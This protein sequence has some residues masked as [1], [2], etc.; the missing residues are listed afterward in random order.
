MDRRKLIVGGG[1][2]AVAGT[3]TAVTGAMMPARAASTTD[4]AQRVLDQVNIDLGLVNPEGIQ[5][6]FDW[7]CADALAAP[8]RDPYADD[9]D[10]WVRRRMA[11][12]CRAETF[13]VA[14]TE[15]PQARS[16]LAFSYLA[17]S[18]DQDKPLPVLDPGMRVPAVLRILEPDFLPVLLGLITERSS[19]SREFAYALQ[20]T[21]D[22]LD[23]MVAEKL[24]EFPDDS[25]RVQA[26]PGNP[27]G[28]DAL[29]FT[30]GVVVF[31]AFLYWI[32]RG[33]K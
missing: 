24:R 32:K 18:Q 31:L 1:A 5:R 26:A 22:R 23:L 13:T 14:V 8:P 28:K 17:Y 29:E 4:H 12:V 16:L 2:A 20:T 30:A 25:G 33:M 6:Q 10:T 9:L 15:D 7:S 19:A 11:E 21:S 27:S 3:L